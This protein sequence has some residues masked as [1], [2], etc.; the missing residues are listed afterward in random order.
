V[1]G[2]IAYLN[3]FGRFKH[4]HPRRPSG[5]APDCSKRDFDHFNTAVQHLTTVQ[6]TRSVARSL[7]VS[8]AS[9]RHNEHFSYYDTTIRRKQKQSQPLAKLS[10]NL[11]T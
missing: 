4:V 6:L 8:W 9:C 11:T 10:K 5:D 3:T 7:C 2:L 1:I